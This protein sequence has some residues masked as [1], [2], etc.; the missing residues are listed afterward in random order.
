MKTLLALIGAAGA[1]AVLISPAAQA[2]NLNVPG[3]GA[4][5]SQAAVGDLGMSIMSASIRSDGTINRGEGVV[6]S[7]TTKLSTGTYEV[8]FGRDITACA[9]SVTVGEGDIGGA[10]PAVTGV[11][12]RSGN[13][14]GLFIRIVNPPDEASEDRDFF[15]LVYCGR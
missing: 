8:G 12:R 15:V 6:S 13:P 4:V 10:T 9:Y 11:T 1:A 2:K 14:N 5:T 3:P 7:G